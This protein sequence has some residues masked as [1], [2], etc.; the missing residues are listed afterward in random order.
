MKRKSRLEQQTATAEILRVIASSPTDVQPVFDAIVRSAVR[1]CDGV[2]SAVIRFDGELQHFVAQYNFTLAAL[3]AWRRVFP[4]P[5]S[6]INV[7]GRAILDCAV[8]HIEDIETVRRTGAPIREAARTLG[9]RTIL[10]VPMLLAGRPVGTI[11]VARREVKPFS[12]RE[13]ELLQT[14]AAQAVIAIENVRLFQ[15]LE[16]RT[17]ELDALGGRASGAR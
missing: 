2:F 14:F 9:Y 5:P 17:Q 1:L 6:R 4:M 3:D 10:G 12:S 7:S 15:E 11:N 16:A 13:I 8:A